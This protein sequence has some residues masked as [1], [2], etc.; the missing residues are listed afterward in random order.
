MYH[1]A[2]LSFPTAK[3]IFLSQDIFELRYYIFCNP[4]LFF[5]LVFVQ[6]SFHEVKFYFLKDLV[7]GGYK[8]YWPVISDVT[9]FSILVRQLL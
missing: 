9:L 8:T 1:D 6:E 7:Q 3:T 5:E 4:C 2:Q